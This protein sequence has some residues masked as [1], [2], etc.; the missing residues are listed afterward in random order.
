MLWKQNSTTEF[1]TKKNFVIEFHEWHSSSFIH[2]TK[3]NNNTFLYMDWIVLIHWY[4]SPRAKA[5]FENWTI[6]CTEGNQS[7]TFKNTLIV[8]VSQGN[9]ENKKH[10]LFTWFK[11][12]QN[13]Y[14][15]FLFFKK[16]LIANK[17]K[18]IFE[19]LIKVRLS[20]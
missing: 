1:Y 8:K 16:I 11:I 19:V 15:M 20:N 17:I 4:F 9:Q 7:L 6:S 14:T 12:I 13:L 5:S 18:Y 3:R 10:C 2:L